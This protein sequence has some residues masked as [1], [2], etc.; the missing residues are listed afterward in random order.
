M[1]ACRHDRDS[2]GCSNRQV[3]QLYLQ[4][5]HRQKGKKEKKKKQDTKSHLHYIWVSVIYG[6]E[7]RKLYMSLLICGLHNGADVDGGGDY[8]AAEDLTDNAVEES[9]CHT[10]DTS[11]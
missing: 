10:Q 3:H 11:L 9:R 8:T 2:S 5:K 4:N 6:D 1:L 7:N